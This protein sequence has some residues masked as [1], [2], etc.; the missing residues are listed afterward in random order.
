MLVGDPRQVTYHTHDEAKYKKYSEGKIVDFIKNEC[1]SCS[2]V[3]DD[4]TLNI[5][6]R[7]NKAICDFANSIYS[8]YK[9]CE[10]KGHEPTG[11]DGVFFISPKEVDS[12]LSLY[13]P[14][15]LRDTKKTS[16]ND[17]YPAIN[18]GES[19]GL[20]FERVLIYP[21][22]KMIDWILDNKKELKPQSKAKFYV[23]VTRAKHSVAIVFDNKKNIIVQGITNFS[24]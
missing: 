21:T 10:C 23:G 8:E 4:T 5:T 9:P 15:Q 16:V 14:M 22:S 2:V 19:K 12:Y 18:L 6:Y 20:T 11:H 13:H 17:E 24:F 1:Q 3:I 7:N